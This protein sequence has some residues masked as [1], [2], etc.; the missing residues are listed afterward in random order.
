[1][2]PIRFIGNEFSVYLN[3]HLANLPHRQARED[4]EEDGSNIL[5]I[6][7]KNTGWTFETEVDSEWKT[8]GMK[9]ETFAG[10]SSLLRDHPDLAAKIFQ[11]VELRV[12]SGTYTMELLL[13]SAPP[14]DATDPLAKEFPFALT[15][16]Y[17]VEVQPGMT[18]VQY[19]AIPDQWSRILPSPAAPFNRV[20]PWINYGMSRPPD[21]DGYWQ[22]EL[23][24]LAR[25]IESF[26][27]DPLVGLLREA[28]ADT[29]SSARGI[30]LLGLPPRLGGAREFDGR[31]ARQLLAAIEDQHRYL[32][33]HEEVRYCTEKAPQF[34][35]TYQQY[36]A[37]V[38][39]VESEMNSHREYV[40][41]LL[42][43]R[44]GGEQ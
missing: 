42:R 6:K 19:V 10:L 23:D 31:L 41:S 9:N 29:R 37:I 30:A 2:V 11:P 38:S 20:C 17:Q 26:Q 33:S 21:E 18:V 27:A 43:K 15:R 39:E 5:F 7:E 35:R 1:M 13:S 24:K 8:W 28:E 34:S 44:D 25:E 4:D 32:P 16:K 36:D 40:E 12:P 14:P 3:G 22:K